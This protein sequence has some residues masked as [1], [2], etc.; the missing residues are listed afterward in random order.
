M[1]Y[2]TKEQYEYRRMAAAQRNLENETIA[3]ANGLTEEQADAI[4]SLCS[5]RHE[6]HSNMNT[7]VDND[8]NHIK[9]RLYE[10]T[11]KMHKL[12]LE[13]IKGIPYCDGCIDILEMEELYEIE[14]WPNPDTQE[15]QD[16]YDE[17][18]GRIYRELEDLNDKIEDWLG[19]IDEKYG[20]KFKPTG[21]LRIVR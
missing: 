20:T 8:Y 9:D 2:L 6:L 15:W 13:P 5:L 16:K 1:A 3:I 21:A 14:D 10:L 19:E 7:M 11:V 18:S 4:S 17:E 12:G